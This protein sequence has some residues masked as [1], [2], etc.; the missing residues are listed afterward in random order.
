[1]TTG[2][3]NPAKEIAEKFVA[4]ENEAWDK[5]NVDAL[6]EVEDPNIVLHLLGQPD[7][8]GREE[9]KKFI[10]FAREAYS[11][12]QHE[13]F[14]IIGTGDVAAFRYT[15]SL[16]FDKPIEG[17]PPPTGKKIDHQGA[18]FLHIK[19]GKIVEIYMIWDTMTLNQGLGLV[20]ESS[21]LPRGE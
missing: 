14:D 6:D 4:A 21:E 10:A 12:P 17:L 19:K 18:M 15:E 7:I 3:G 8:V 5:G 16:T 9:H 2:A 13:F 20:P 1:M 11:N